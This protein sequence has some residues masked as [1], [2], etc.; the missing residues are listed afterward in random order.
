M[1]TEETTSDG[2][3]K[4]KRYCN[5]QFKKNLVKA[6][7]LNFGEPDNIDKLRG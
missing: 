1:S 7:K 5:K 2:K 4:K 3:V 6:L